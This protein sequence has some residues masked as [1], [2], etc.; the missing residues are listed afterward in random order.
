MNSM[1]KIL[2]P[3]LILLLFYSSAIFAQKKTA[4]AT[5]LSTVPK[6]DG[7]LDD[8]CWAVC[9]SVDDF[10]QYIPVYDVRPSQRTV[11]RIAYDDEAIYVGAMMY[12]TAPDS[13]FREVGTRDDELN[14][15]KFAIQFDTYNMQTDA[16][17]F[18][19]WASGTQADWRQNDETYNAV[20]Q[21]A[22]KIID[23]G[24]V[25]EMKIS[26]SALR[27]P[28]IKEQ[29][30]GMQIFRGIRRH[31]ETDQWALEIKGNANYLKDWGILQGIKEVNPSLRL[32]VTPFISL[33]GDHYP[34]NEKGKSNFSYSFSGGLDLKYGINESF[35]LDVTLLPDFSQVQSDYQ[36]K[37]ITAFETVYEEYRPFFT[38]AI[39]LFKEG[40]L[41]YSRRIGRLPLGFYSVY[42][43]VA[44]GEIIKKNPGQAKLINA[45]KLSGRNK[46]G[47]A[48]GVFNAITNNMYATLEDSTGN[49]RKILT[50]PLTNYNILVLDQIIK[51]NSKIYFVNTN[52]IRDKK[53]DDANVSLLG[54]TLND[55]KNMYQFAG[56][57]A[58]S[59][60]FHKNDTLVKKITN[61]LG[62]QYAVSFGKVSGKFQFSIYRN[63]MNDT[64]DPNDLGL[65]LQNNRTTTGATFKYNIYEPFWKLRDMTNTLNIYH[66]ENFL[67][68]RVEEFQFEY[69]GFVT[70]RKYLS[71]WA[72]LT[73][74]P[75][76]V[77][78]FA[79]TRTPGRFFIIDNWY[80]ASLGISSDYRKKFALDMGVDFWQEIKG[81]G[82]YYGI[83]VNPIV[84]PSNKFTFDI[85]SKYEGSYNDIGFVYK[86]DIG[87]IIIGKRDIITVQ[88]QF[89]GRY[90]FRN[91]LALSLL[92][93]HYWSK[94]IYEQHYKLDFDGNLI[95]DPLL[96]I[97]QNYNF[98]FN[99]FNIDLLFYWEFSPG[100]SLNITYKNN[101][102]KE[103]SQ[104]VPSYFK[105]FG[106]IFA[107][108]QLNSLSVKV[109]YYLDY[110]QVKGWGNKKKQKKKSDD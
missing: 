92:V 83:T 40:D 17:T 37:N 43:S 39:D 33:Y 2:W 58:L 15:D 63:E 48:V 38:E 97:D 86:D 60:K 108:K 25:C 79:D 93:R 52:V 61:T 20:W 26:Y 1:Y 45:I 13:I 65:V 90:M 110:Q 41:F 42:D 74:S 85:A 109:I 103:G 24:W 59:M 4:H 75:L 3:S 16:Y 101:I 107:E 73:V 19:V 100:S 27:F 14:A 71:I 44:E 5:R 106:N 22:T 57:A 11:V 84:K 87:N 12:D 89:E 9:D 49:T 78:V 66:T 70:T 7:V 35:T 102:L 68:K 23:K 67:A 30:W 21:S 53:Y 64:W 94:G 29:N 99:A 32:S 55:K 31:R 62:Y 54:L 8:A 72:K 36:V 82:V 51:N 34:Y 91:N 98:N 81:D 77:N 105:N 104:I 18:A 28:K 10:T 69:T 88:N 47:T 46:K 50:E 6:V 95:T 76:P 56:S 96:T 80:Y